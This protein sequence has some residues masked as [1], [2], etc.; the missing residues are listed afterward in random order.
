[1]PEVSFTSFGHCYYILIIAHL[2]KSGVSQKDEDINAC[3]NFLE[4]LAYRT[5]SSPTDGSDGSD[6]IEELLQ[7]IGM[8][9]ISRSLW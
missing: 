7:V 5:F 4:K 6:K 3:F 2:V 1:M 9:I 8:S